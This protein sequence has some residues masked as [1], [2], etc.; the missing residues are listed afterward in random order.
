MSST[1]ACPEVKEDY[2]DIISAVSGSGPA[3]IYV[4]ISALADGAVKCGLPRSL[5]QSLAA[6]MVK[7]AAMMVIQTGKHPDQ[8]TIQAEVQYIPKYRKKCLFMIL[9]N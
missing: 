2:L 5:A 1:G 9:M 4:M 7:G 8:V 3:Y 6:D